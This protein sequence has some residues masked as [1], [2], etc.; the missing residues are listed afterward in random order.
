MTHKFKAGQLVSYVPAR[1]V[2]AGGRAYQ[3]VKCLPSE[4][5]QYLYRIKSKSETFDRIARE[6]ELDDRR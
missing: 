2:L 6:S 5:G 4:G 1:G 3:I